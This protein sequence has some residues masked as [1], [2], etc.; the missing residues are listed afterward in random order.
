L[1]P[2]RLLIL[3]GTGEASALAASLARREDVAAIVSLA[4]RTQNPALSALPTRIGGFGGVA[5]LREYLQTD[6]IDAVIDA[7]HPFAAQ[8]SRHAAEACA[9]GGVALLRF[10]RPPWAPVGGDNWIEV[11]GI[12]AAVAALGEAPRRVLLTQGRMQVAAFARAPQHHYVVRAI[13]PPADLSTLPS[14]RLILARGPFVLAQEEALLRE[15]RIELLV[16]KNS[17]GAATHAKIE[18]ARLLAVPVVML[19]R[20]ALPDVERT[21]SLG[22]VMEWIEARLPSPRVR[23]NQSHRER[24]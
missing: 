4:G 19:S 3:G 16:S 12:E 22:A 14:H 18:A 7:T 15:E 21:H 5:G 17:G 9:A 13:E 20:P 23:E 6:G 8:M 1:Q 11:A 10:T 24:P 2:L